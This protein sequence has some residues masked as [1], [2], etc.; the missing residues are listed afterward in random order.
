MQAISWTRL[1]FH[2]PSWRCSNT[3]VVAV[4]VCFR[5]FTRPRKFKLSLIVTKAFCLF[6][7]AYNYYKC[8]PNISL[9]SIFFA[10]NI[11][12]CCSPTNPV[13]LRL[14][15]IPYSNTDAWDIPVNSLGSTDHHI[16]QMS[17]ISFLKITFYQRNV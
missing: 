8:L 17:N 10:N 4:N 11:D 7:D 9:P 5:L 1:N 2:R 12:F 15:V 16:L 13:I 14:R 6:I 3:Y